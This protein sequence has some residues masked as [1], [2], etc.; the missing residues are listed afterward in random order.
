M[1]RVPPAQGA[2]ARDAPALQVL[3]G[4]MSISRALSPHA[5]LTARCQPA[6]LRGCTGLSGDT[7]LAKVLRTPLRL[8][9]AGRSSLQ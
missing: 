3:S 2:R 7:S 9:A 8:P 6:V 1:C 4:R 5:V